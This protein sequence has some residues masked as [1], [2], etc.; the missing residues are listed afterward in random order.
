MTRS[1]PLGTISITILLLVVSTHCSSTIAAAQTK[2]EGVIK[3]PQRLGSHFADGGFAE[4]HR[5][6]D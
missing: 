4:G 1:K 5:P 6:A 3:G 2:L